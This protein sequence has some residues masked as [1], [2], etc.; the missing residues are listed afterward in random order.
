MKPKA[1]KFYINFIIVMLILTGAIKTLFIKW[2]NKTPMSGDDIC[3]PDE[4]T[5]K[6]VHPFI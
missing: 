3:P 6:F 2:E 1:S 4:V 5:C